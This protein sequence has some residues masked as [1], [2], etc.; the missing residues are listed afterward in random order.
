MG[1][2]ALRVVVVVVVVVLE[3]VVVVGLRPK[4]WLV[5]CVAKSSQVAIDGN[6]SSITSRLILESAPTSVLSVRIGRTTSLLWIDM[7]VP[8]TENI[9]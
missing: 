5:Q 2:A 9:L 6:V 8:C 3:V 7:F 4:A 1:V